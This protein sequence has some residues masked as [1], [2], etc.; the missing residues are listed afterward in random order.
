MLS[1]LRDP[2][3]RV[4]LTNLTLLVALFPFAIAIASGVMKQT[5]PSH[6]KRMLNNPS[7]R[8]AADAIQR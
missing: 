2:T 4:K 7:V 8:Y 1:K 3:H 5:K 6:A